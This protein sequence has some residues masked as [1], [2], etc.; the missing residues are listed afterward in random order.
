[1]HIVAGTTLGGV[2]MGLNVFASRL[3][4][5]HS[6]DRAN[7]WFSELPYVRRDA[8]LMRQLAVGAILSESNWFPMNTLDPCKPRAQ[9][10]AWLQTSWMVT[11]SQ[12]A[13]A[14][15]QWL[16]REG[17]SRIFNQI[18]ELA[19]THDV[20]SIRAEISNRLGISRDDVELREFVDNY[21][22]CIPWLREGRF[23]LSP[24]SLERGTG[25]YDLGRAVTVARVAF[26]AGYLTKRQAM[27]AIHSAAAQAAQSFKSWAQFSDSYLLGRAIWS[28]V[29]DPSLVD[30]RKIVEAL[31]NQPDSPWVRFGYL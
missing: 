19:R 1:M 21:A 8:R 6:S 23:L 26:G 2:I 16:L 20:D 14:T 30:M 24:D 17:H 18:I 12:Q 7:T 25:A 22:A 27:Q 3:T 5:R 9:M 4:Y 11:D 15:L 28:G 29:H 31:R 13:H 10:R